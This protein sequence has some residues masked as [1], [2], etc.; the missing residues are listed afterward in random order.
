LVL[1]RFDPTV[2]TYWEERLDSSNQLRKQC[3]ND[4]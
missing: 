3:V 2:C 4:H 1:V